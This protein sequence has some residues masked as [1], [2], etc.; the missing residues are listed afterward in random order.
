[1]PE[2]KLIQDL[3]AARRA[4]VPLLAIETADP[5]ACM[6]QIKD[7]F[8]AKGPIPLGSWDKV[9]GFKSLNKEGEAA[10]GQALGNMD[11]GTESW[12]VEEPDKAYRAMLNMPRNTIIFY[13]NGHWYFN[14]AENVQAYWNLRDELKRDKRM[15][16]IL[17]PSLKLPAELKHDVVVLEDPLPGSEELLSV[18]KAV[19]KASGVEEKNLPK[20]ETLP[21]A[22]EAVRGLSA[23]SAEQ[24]LA[25]SM[26]KEGSHDPALNLDR[27]WIKKKKTIE[28]SPSLR[29]YKGKETFADVRGIQ[30]FKD[31]LTKVMNGED[32]PTV[33]VFWDE[34]EKAFAGTQG[35]TSGVSQEMHGQILSWMADNDVPAVRMV[36]HPG[37]SKSYISKSLGGEFSIP[38]IIMNI[39]EAKN[40]LVGKST[41]NLKEDLK[42]ISAVGRP[43]VLATCNNEEAL[44]PELRDRFNLGTWFFDLPSEEELRAVFD[45]WM[46]KFKLKGELPADHK[47]WTQRNA[48]D[49]CQLAWRLRTSL[50]EASR[51]IVPVKR[52]NPQRIEE[53]RKKANG[54]YLSVSKGGVYT[55]SN[56]SRLQEATIRSIDLDNSVGQA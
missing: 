53:L 7:Y 43:I 36:G 51:F 54:K 14:T 20:D 47:D 49:C 10:I 1:M 25:M 17:C 16:I 38:M 8:K 34:L 29:I 24:V 4:G 13:L 9:A 42:V 26:E 52:S 21:K 55:Y 19:Y 15:A 12:P 41:E 39:S 3:A 48:H 22:V 18:V 40:S 23:F 6:R 46:G 32:R 30:P 11:T 33:G 35:D 31:F 44:S 28:M 2:S 37:C 56:S 5:A 27:L 45:V 50:E